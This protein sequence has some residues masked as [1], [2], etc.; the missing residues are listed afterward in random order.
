MAAAKSREPDPLPDQKC[1]DVLVIVA[2][3]EK[4]LGVEIQLARERAFM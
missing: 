2:I 4:A 3:D 1:V